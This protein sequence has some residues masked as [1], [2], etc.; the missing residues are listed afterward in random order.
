MYWRKLPFPN[1]KRAD[2]TKVTETDVFMRDAEWISYRRL[3]FVVV[4]PRKIKLVFQV[5]NVVL[6]IVNLFG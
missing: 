2:T 4:D 1:V 3:E 6:E 5:L